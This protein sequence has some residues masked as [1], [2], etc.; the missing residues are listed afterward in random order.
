[1]WDR[2]TENKIL[3]EKIS[4]KSDTAVGSNC[5]KDDS[6]QFITDQGRI[7]LLIAAM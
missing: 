2:T 5:M 3:I 1:M 7:Q 4:G 6:S